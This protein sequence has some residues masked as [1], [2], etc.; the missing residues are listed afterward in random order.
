MSER[1]VPREVDVPKIPMTPRKVNDSSDKLLK[2]K[3]PNAEKKVPSQNLTMINGIPTNLVK[4]GPGSGGI[5][6]TD[7]SVTWTS[8]PPFLSKLGKVPGIYNLTLI[9]EQI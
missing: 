4:I 3:L 6:L 8:L 7:G 1:P 9:K 5:K 2:P